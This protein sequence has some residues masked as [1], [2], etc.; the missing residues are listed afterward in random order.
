[1]RVPTLVIVG[2][3]DRAV[4]PD[5]GRL[6]ARCIPGARL[7]ELATNHHPGDEAP[8]ASLQAL[9]EFLAG[10]SPSSAQSPDEGI[11]LESPSTAAPG[12][13]RPETS[14]RAGSRT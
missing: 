11:K 8:E 5:E 2:T 6:A 13:M 9:D 4:P 1:V 7:V 10:L 12:K 14:R 3:L